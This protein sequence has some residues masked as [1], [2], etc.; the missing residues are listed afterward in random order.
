MCDLTGCAPFGPGAMAV[1]CISGHFLRSL[2]HLS[3]QCVRHRKLTFQATVR[4][5]LAASSLGE[6]YVPPTVTLCPAGMDSAQSSCRADLGFS[7][8]RFSRKWKL[9]AVSTGSNFVPGAVLLWNGPER[10]TTYVD[11]S[12]LTLPFRRRTLPNLERLR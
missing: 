7:I 11:S 5:I 1:L 8:Q 4:V 12:H 10:A 9:H 2:I 3:C 6:R